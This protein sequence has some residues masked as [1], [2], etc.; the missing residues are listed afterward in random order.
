MRYNKRS[1][2]NPIVK[3]WILLKLI[4]LSAVLSFLCS[5]AS[6]TDRRLAREIEED[7]ELAAFEAATRPI[8]K[9]QPPKEAEPAPEK[10]SA[11]T[12]MLTG[13]QTQFEVVEESSDSQGPTLFN[14]TGYVS[15]NVVKRLVVA[16]GPK[17]F[18]GNQDLILRSP[19]LPTYRPYHPRGISHYRPHKPTYHPNKPKYHPYVSTFARSGAL[20]FINN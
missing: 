4:A 16:S 17:S 14:N 15:E 5:T 10:K 9:P 13:A 20:G 3:Q 1:M 6:A 12:A 19:Y 8:E 11:T 18:G 7:P 2:F